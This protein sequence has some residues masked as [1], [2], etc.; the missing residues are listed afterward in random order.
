ME[1]FANLLRQDL[2]FFDKP[3]NAS[4]ALA[5]RLSSVPAAI[6]DLLG[7]NIALILIIFVNIIASSVLALIVGWKLGLAVVFGVI[8]PL[9]FFGYLRIRLETKLEAQ[10]AER[11]SES[12]S[13]AGEAMNAI[14]TIS[15][16]SME[17]DVIERY[18]SSLEAIERRAAGSVFF[19]MF[20][21]ALSQ[22]LDA[23]ALGLGFW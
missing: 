20:W 23:L 7:F 9:V 2:R 19:T 16:L 22:S 11:F 17:L 21:F 14:R 13:L 4:G 3:E 12:A 5:S 1:M 6:Q 15:S 8:P 10:N 18:T